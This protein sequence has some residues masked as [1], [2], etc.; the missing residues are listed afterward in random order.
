PDLS[1]WTVD[2]FAMGGNA[3]AATSLGPITPESGAHFAAMSN[4]S[5]GFSFAQNAEIYQRISILPGGTSSRFVWF[6]ADTTAGA[7]VQSARVNLF[8]TSSGV[9]AVTLTS[10]TAGWTPFSYTFPPGAVTTQQLSLQLFCATNGGCP[11]EK[12]GFDNITYTDPPSPT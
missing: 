4:P 10:T 11:N 6:F 12:V 9:D 5:G 7:P 8:G 3:T 1:G 2:I